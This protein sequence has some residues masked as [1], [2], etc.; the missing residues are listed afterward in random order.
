MLGVW[1][2]VAQGT[3]LPKCR[4]PNFSNIF[5]DSCTTCCTYHTFICNPTE[6]YNNNNKNF[7]IMKEAFATIE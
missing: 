6:P 5:V 3:G 4:T 2:P 1:R 7:V